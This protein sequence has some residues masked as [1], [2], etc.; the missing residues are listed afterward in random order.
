[1]KKKTAMVLVCAICAASVA[2][3]V[4]AKGAYKK[5]K[6]DAK[7]DVVIQLD[8]EESSQST[9]VSKET[10]KRHQ[11]S[12]DTSE[13]IGVDKAKKAALERAGLTSVQV[14]WVKAELDRDD[15][16]WKYEID[17]KHNGYEYEA[18]INAYDGSVMKFEKEYDD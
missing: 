16:I 7:S 5:A 15:G 11:K 9:A 3:G 17:F 2:V 10:T 12:V 8:D 1:M 4:A 13:F 18:E 6:K 14:P